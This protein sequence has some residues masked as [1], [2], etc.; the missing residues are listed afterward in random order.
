MKDAAIEI[1]IYKPDLD[2]PLPADQRGV[3]ENPRIKQRF[4]QSVTIGV[5]LDPPDH[6]KL[7]YYFFD[8]CN[9]TPLTTYDSLD[10]LKQCAPERVGSL[11]ESNPKLFIMGHGHGGYYGLSNHL[12][13]ESEIIHGDDFD[14]IIKDFKSALPLEKQQALHV[15]LE[16]CNTDNKANALQVTKEDKTFLQRL[17]ATHKEITFGGSGPWDGGDF[18]TGFRGTTREA[19]ITS[20]VGNIWKHGNSVIFHDDKCQVAV[21][22]SLFATTASAKAMKLNTL[23]YAREALAEEGGE[24]LIQQIALDRDVLTI[25]DVNRKGYLSASI[26]D[27]AIDDKYLT[28]E[29]RITAQEQASYQ[30]RVQDILTRADPIEQLSDRDPLDITLGLKDPSVFKGHERL[31]ISVLAN[32][33]LLN[34]AMISCGKV[35]VGSPSN[36]SIIDVL[37]K[38]GIDINAIDKEGMTA[39]HH[40]AQDFF[41]YRKEPIV[42][43]KKLLA[44]GARLDLKDKQGRTPLICA[45]VHCQDTRVRE[46]ESLLHYLVQQSVRQVFQM[47]KFTAGKLLSLPAHLSEYYDCRLGTLYLPDTVT[48]QLHQ[49]LAPIK[50][51]DELISL[52]ELELYAVCSELNKGEGTGE[53][54]DADDEIVPKRFDLQEI[55]VKL[56]SIR[57]ILHDMKQ[58]VSALPVVEDQDFTR[59]V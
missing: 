31:L 43:I 49:I 47:D 50:G 5:Y 3:V 12:H 33:P 41:N 22:K 29:A 34:L 57:Q 4:K 23:T 8:D 58:V 39:L 15:T 1:L 36:D 11:F 48:E 20:T 25:E 17:S 10:D 52:F 44:T 59:R 55:E 46:K 42:L 18:E 24:K 56:S 38:N 37:L 7:K 40:A 53:A 6:N 19:L 16:A 14:Q 28:Q 27:A 13:G 54:F 26:H 21:R 30:E 51:D 9:K 45:L 35:L 32:K 2:K